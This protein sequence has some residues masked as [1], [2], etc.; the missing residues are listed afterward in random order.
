V[1]VDPGN[2]SKRFRLFYYIVW[3]GVSDVAG[4][5]LRVLVCC[6]VSG[7]LMAWLGAIKASEAPRGPA[8]D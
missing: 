8:R 3:S 7:V 6:D 4:M 2:H 1:L 5:G